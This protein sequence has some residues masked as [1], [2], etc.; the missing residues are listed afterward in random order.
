VTKDG[1]PAAQRWLKRRESYLSSTGFLAV[2]IG[3]TFSHRVNKAQ[4]R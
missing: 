2:Y 1:S 3:L 4:A